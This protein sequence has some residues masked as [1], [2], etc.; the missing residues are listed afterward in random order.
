[1][2]SILTGTK[3]SLGITEDNTDFD[4]ILIVHINTVLNI[5]TQLGVGPS[6]GFLISDASTQWED[7]LEKS[8]LLDLTKTYMSMKVRMMFDPP[9]SSSVAEAYNR[10]IS[11]LEY[12][13][14]IIVDPEKVSSA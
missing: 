1:M 7:L 11:E 6:D 9:T 8:K 10:M 4:E 2:S 3:L 5:L 12:R 14:N 13:I